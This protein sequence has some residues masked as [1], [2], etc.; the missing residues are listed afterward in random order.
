MCKNSVLV[1][2]LVVHVVCILSVTF[3]VCFC[4]ITLVE[5][6][7]DEQNILICFFLPFLVSSTANMM[8]KRQT[9]LTEAKH[10]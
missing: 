3:Q 7:E 1:L 9:D 10:K 6:I 2:Y 4:F 8:K 5:V